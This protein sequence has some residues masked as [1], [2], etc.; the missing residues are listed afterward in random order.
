MSDRPFKDQDWTPPVTNT[1][2]DNWRQAQLNL[3]MDIRDELKEIKLLLTKEPR[4]VIN[5]S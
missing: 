1:F 5:P 4:E 3:L 2:E